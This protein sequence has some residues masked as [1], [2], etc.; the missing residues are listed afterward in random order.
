MNYRE[1]L[2]PWAI[3]RIF[4]NMERISISRFRSRSDA[5]GHLKFLRQQIPNASFEVIFDCQPSSA[6]KQSLDE[7]EQPQEVQ[8]T[9]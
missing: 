2:N 1:R 3:V 6:V 5:D 7:Q 8:L 4:P 9:S